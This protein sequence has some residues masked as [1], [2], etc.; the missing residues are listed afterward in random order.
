[1]AAAWLLRGC[2]LY[3]CRMFALWPLLDRY[4]VALAL[5]RCRC[6]GSAEYVCGHPPH[7]SAVKSYTTYLLRAYYYL[8]FS[9]DGCGTTLQWRRHFLHQATCLLLAC[10]IL[11]RST[12]H[13]SFPTTFSRLPTTYY[14]LRIRTICHLLPTNY[15]LRP[16]YD[17]HPYCLLPTAHEPPTTAGYL[18]LTNSHPPPNCVAT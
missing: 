14:S 6:G 12:N 15:Y 4:V 1:M 16:T 7:I 2:L 17:L 5:L 11:L 9:L 8:Y 10:C 3:D 18:L 13:Y